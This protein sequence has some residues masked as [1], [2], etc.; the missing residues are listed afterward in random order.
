M[1]RNHIWLCRGLLTLV[2]M[3][4]LALPAAADAA[5]ETISEAPAAENGVFCFSREELDR[6]SALEGVFV[7]ALPA[8]DCGR[9]L[10]GSRAL[11]VGDAVT[12]ADLSRLRLEAVKGGDAVLTF[13][14][15]E[16]G[17][18]GEQTVLTFHLES[19]EEEPPKALPAQIETWRNLPNTG[20]LRASG[21]GKLRFQLENRPRRGSVE[22]EPDG[23]FSYT[24]KK[25]K[26]GEDS[27]SFTVSNEAGQVSE[28][29]TVRVT[30][31]KPTDAQTFADLD[32]DQQF[33]ALWMRETGLFGGELISERLSF[34]PEQTVSR[35]DFLAMVMDLE[36]I[37]PEIGL[38]VSAFA[39][40]EDAAPWLRPYLASA[41]RRGL[42]QGERSAEGLV[43]RPNE[44][45]TVAEAAALTARVFD[46]E[47]AIPAACADSPEVPLTRMQAAELLYEASKQ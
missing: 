4:A 12:R 34:G 26:V 6:R 9:V 7:T 22:L 15:F 17:C 43:Y 23:S 40:A 33:A 41:L 32:R 36:G 1:R 21:S 20:K 42:I 27:F 38:Q 10:L 28:P 2:L 3:L 11:R 37:E 35:G 46:T 39:D 16:D 13:L 25:N 47:L 30:I 19:S 14:P 8:E 5:G 18:L 29:A 31:R 45:V 44:A 24:P